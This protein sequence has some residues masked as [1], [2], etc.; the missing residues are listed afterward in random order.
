MSKLNLTRPKLIQLIH[1]AKTKLMMDESSYRIMLEKL[2]GK[3]S[4]R[5]MGIAEL[6]RVYDHMK[7][8]GFKVQPKKGLSPVTENAR[9]KSNIA[10]KI[11]AVWI[12]MYKSGIIKDGSEQA[13]NKFMHKSLFKGQ[14]RQKHALIKL[15]VQSLD[16]REA[17]QLLEMLKKWQGRMTK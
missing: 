16:N 6:M 10:H 12:D 9:V 15:N 13:L 2:T 5:Q 3:T 4:C 7:K 8:K 1:V 11:R 17:T 14:V